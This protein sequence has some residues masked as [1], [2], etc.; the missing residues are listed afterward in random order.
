M[1]YEEENKDPTN[2][3]NLMH[4][5][6]VVLFKKS[7][8]EGFNSLGSH[9]KPK[10]KIRS[11]HSQITKSNLNMAEY[12]NEIDKLRKKLPKPELKTRELLGH[13]K[14]VQNNPKRIKQN[15]LFI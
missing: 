6:F 3:K 12:E 2:K 5:I 11:P 7:T 15:N 10:L 1:K 13:K 9:F 8:R 14:K 4:K